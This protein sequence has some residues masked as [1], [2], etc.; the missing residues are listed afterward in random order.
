MSEI[1][2]GG[3]K[4]RIRYRIV[5]VRK[6]EPPI[7]KVLKIE[8]PPK[9]IIGIRHR[10]K[11]TAEG[12]SRPTQI[13]VVEDGNGIRRDL[14]DER[15]E[16]ELVQ[17]IQSGD[18]IAMAMG[19]SGD[20]LAYAASR[21]ARE[22]GA[23]VLRTPPSRLNEA[24]GDG[25]KDD[26][27]ALLA[28]LV[29]E[30]PAIF[31]PVGEIDAG[32][33]LMREQFRLWQDA[34]KARI[35]CQQRL[36][37]RLIGNVFTSEGGI[38]PEGGIEKMFDDAKANDAILTALEKEETK[39]LNAMSKTLKKQHRVYR[40][41]FEPIV[42]VGPSLASRIIYP[43]Q[44]IRLFEKDSQLKKYLGVHVLPDGRFPRK[45]VGEIA[46]WHDDARK[47][48]YL[49]ADQF[50]KRPES[51]WGIKFRHAKEL[52]KK[53]HPEPVPDEKGVMKWTPIHIH[54]TAGWRTLGWFVEH[55]HKE[56]TKLAEAR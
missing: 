48:L 39:A 4:Y 17:S 45:R 28:K 40:E 33:I 50:N 31:Y 23:K 11:K 18:V 55:V 7:V 1:F 41:V 26:D 15:E 29:I 27:A 8:P 47:G 22:R 12:E 37:Q 13:V 10:V 16:F 32:H 54:R 25:S 6:V 38:F 35:A 44:D 53:S 42:G 30:R 43:V 36:Y 52:I 19:G 21:V 49:L 3:K 56:W 5:K 51:E 9:R 2:I 34:M 24:R 20:Y 14:K 46:N